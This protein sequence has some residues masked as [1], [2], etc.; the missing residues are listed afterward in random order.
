ML[1]GSGS[2]KS[3]YGNK[4]KIRRI[5]NFFR[6]KCILLINYYQVLLLLHILGGGLLFSLN[7]YSYVLLFKFLTAE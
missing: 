7:S 6:A 1:K 2:Q 3:I 4:R 5:M